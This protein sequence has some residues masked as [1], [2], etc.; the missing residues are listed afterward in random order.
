MSDAE[1]SLTTAEQSAKSSESELRLL[2]SKSSEVESQLATVRR[3]RDHLEQRASTAQAKLQSL[4]DRALQAERDRASWE[5]EMTALG[6]QL[7][8]EMMKRIQLEKTHKAVS[9]E[10]D[11]LQMRLVEQDQYVKGLRRELRDKEAELAKSISLQDKTIVEHV[12]VLEEAKRYTD[13]QLSECVHFDRPSCLR[14]K[15]MLTGEPLFRARTQA[16]L[17]SIIQYSRTLEKTK[18]RL[19]A[20]LEDLTV[21]NERE[22]MDER[23]M[24]KAFRKVEEQAEKANKRLQQEERMRQVAEQDAARLTAEV[25]RLRAA[26]AANGAGSPGVGGL[27]SNGI[28]RSKSAFENIPPPSSPVDGQHTVNGVQT[29]RGLIAELEKGTIYSKDGSK[30]DALRGRILRELTAA[31]RDL[32]SSMDATLLR[33]VGRR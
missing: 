13:K 32:A 7:E 10:I 4:E 3:E 11:G 5:R 2:K 21:H 30:D 31:N 28:Q 17:A 16:R 1:R 27:A 25:A 23:A 14:C 19:Q 20:E 24:E 29:K 9:S 22:R 12:H 33:G 8:A 18:T 26:G 6:D 15:L